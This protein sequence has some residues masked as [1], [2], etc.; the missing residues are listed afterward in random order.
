MQGAEETV[1]IDTYHLGEEQVFL[2]STLQVQ[3]ALP[4][5][6]A[7]LDSLSLTSNQP[8]DS[9]WFS[10]EESL[11]EPF[12]T[13]ISQ[14]SHWGVPLPVFTHESSS[15]VLCNTLITQHLAKLVALHGLDALSSFPPD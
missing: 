1:L 5:S 8:A 9:E 14:Q 11:E 4:S 13:R 3:L 6:S 7:L 2:R 15:E 12:S 10:L